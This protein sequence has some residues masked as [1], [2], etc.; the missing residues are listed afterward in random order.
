MLDCPHQPLAFA[1]NSLEEMLP[2]ASP[3]LGSLHREMA[4]SCVFVICSCVKPSARSIKEPVFPLTVSLDKC[5]VYLMFTQDEAN[6][7][8]LL[9]YTFF[10]LRICRLWL[11]KYLESLQHLPSGKG[12]KCVDKEWVPDETGKMDCFNRCYWGPFAPC[13]MLSS[14]PIHHAHSGCVAA[15]HPHFNR[16]LLPIRQS[17]GLDPMPFLTIWEQAV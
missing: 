2:L 14:H 12:N 5:E 9:F 6:M 8:L 17:A 11:L 15:H 1:V 7:F 10:L 4:F 3:R 16:P 13:L